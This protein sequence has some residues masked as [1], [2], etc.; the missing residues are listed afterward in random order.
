M[1]KEKLFYDVI[2]FQSVNCTKSDKKIGHISQKKSNALKF[3]KK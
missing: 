1:I 3:K 2:L